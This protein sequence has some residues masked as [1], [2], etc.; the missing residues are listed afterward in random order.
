MYQVPKSNFRT[1]IEIKKSRFIANLYP[2]TTRT[3]ALSHLETVRNEFSSANHHCWAY[4]LGDPG[5]NCSAASDDDGE[6]SGTAGRPILNVLQHKEAGDT[7]IIVS[8]Y[9]GGIKLGAGGLVRA[10]SRAAQGAIEVSQFCWFEKSVSVKV[11]FEFSFE[12]MIRH[13]VHSNQSNIINVAY[14]A[15]VDMEIEIPKSKLMDFEKYLQNNNIGTFKLANPD[16][17]TS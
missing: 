14:S 13:W 17:V 15:K 11:G 3:A 12:N 1:E 9:F 6:P 5:K 8:R 7:I 10:Y 16:Q 2:A 4:I